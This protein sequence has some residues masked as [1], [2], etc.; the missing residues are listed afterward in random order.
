[1]KVSRTVILSDMHYPETDM[2]SFGAA[3]QFIQ[4]TKPQRIILLGDNLDC[5]AVSR[6]SKGKPG[7]REKGGLRRDLDG[8]NKHI[9][10]PLES[11]SPKAERIIFEGNHE[12]WLQQLLEEQPELQGCLELPKLLDLAARDWQW[13]PQGETRFV[14]KVMFLHGDQV[15]SSIHVAKKLVDSYCATAVMG[16]VHTLS[17]YTKTSAARQR[18]KWVGVTLPALC[19][20]APRYAKGRPNA[21]LKG[22]GILEEWGKFFNLYIAIITDG[23]FVYGG[24]R[25]AQ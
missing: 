17:M 22:I 15:G 14:G 5:Q 2:A 25:Y 11:A 12:A 19:D 23:A 18:D 7:L 3:L 20:L 9:L 8:F 10:T 16:H 4:E 21:W 13:V 6:H 1:M 24:K